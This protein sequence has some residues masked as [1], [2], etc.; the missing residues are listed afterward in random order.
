MD[1]ATLKAYF[2]INSESQD[3]SSSDN[4]LRHTIAEYQQNS[5][6]HD[7]INVPTAK[8]PWTTHNEEQTFFERLIDAHE[9]GDIPEGFLLTENERDGQPYPDWECIPGGRRG[10]HEVRLSMPLGIWY[11]RAVLWSQAL[12]AMSNVLLDRTYEA[13]FHGFHNT[14]TD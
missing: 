10:K 3:G 8:M 1:P 14:D 4:Q 9:S 6:R 2:G 13:E 7:A 5:I 11:P 12:R